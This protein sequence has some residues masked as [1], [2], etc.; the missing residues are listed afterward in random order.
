MKRIDDYDNIKATEGGDFQKNPVGG[1]VCRIVDVKNEEAREYLIVEFD[2][3]EGDY[4]G[5]YSDL[6]TRAGFW[7]LKAFK[8]YKEKNMKYFKGFITA[9]EQSNQGYKWD[10][11]ENYLKDRFIGLVIGEEEYI[12][13]NGAVGT[14]AVV[15]RNTSVENIRKGNYEVPEKIKLKEEVSV[16]I[17]TPNKVD[18]DLP[19]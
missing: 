16:T 1:F 5:Y 7:G 14:R 8:S 11:N 12:K 10:W 2:I 18:D 3:M 13:N 6:F 15:V 9:V 19:F 4:A 17:K